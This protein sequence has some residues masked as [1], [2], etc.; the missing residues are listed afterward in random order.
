MHTR[1]TKTG[2]WLDQN[3]ADTY[4]P[5]YKTLLDVLL[6]E[7]LDSIK[8]DNVLPQGYEL[9]HCDFYNL[10]PSDQTEILYSSGI[11]RYFIN[12]KRQTQ[13]NFTP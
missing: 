1:K 4:S 7:R 12:G 3:G 8:T 6:L 2:E 11:I 5:E 10:D 13:I 9:H